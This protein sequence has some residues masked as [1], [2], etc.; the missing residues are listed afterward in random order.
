[1]AA[2]EGFVPHDAAL[3]ANATHQMTEEALAERQ[4]ALHGHAGTN[5]SFQ[6]DIPSKQPTNKVSFLP[7]AV[8]VGY[9]DAETVMYAVKEYVIVKTQKG[10]SLCKFVLLRKQCQLASRPAGS[11]ALMVSCHDVTTCVMCLS[12]VISHDMFCLRLKCA[13]FEGFACEKYSLAKA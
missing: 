12:Q 7:S 2:C 1:M 4:A 11:R 6:V 3:G 8:R 9:N 5:E 10:K 13:T